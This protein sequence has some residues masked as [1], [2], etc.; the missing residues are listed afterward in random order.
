MPRITM[1][2]DNL[3]ARNAEF[4]QVPLK[5]PVFLN[6]VPKCGTHLIR[7]IMRM[8]VPLDQQY[9]ATF[10]QIPNLRSHLPAL[11]PAAPKLSWGHMLF[12]DDS[13]MVLHPVRHILLV[14]DPYD[15]VLARARFFLSEN[16]D[17][18]LSHLRNEAI[19]PEALMNMMIFGIHGKAPTLNE[20]FTFNA[21]AWQGTD[22]RMYRY[23]DIVSNLKDLNSLR[24][25]KFF[26]QLLTDCGIP[27]PDD[28]RERVIIGSDKAQSSTSRDNLNVDDTRLP[29]ELPDAQKQLV[30]F[31]APGLR[32]LLG[33]T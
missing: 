32:A 30:E 26:A 3:N 13:S 7:N 14:R 24:A 8:F 27:V 1:K 20:I 17:G 29:N 10:L 12:S 22:V 33:Y 25:E 15:W 16:F 11:S 4:E 21:A 9:H 28:W 6:S 23:E 2:Q 31:A 19:T 5:Q 18:A